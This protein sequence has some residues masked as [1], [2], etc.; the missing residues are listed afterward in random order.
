V[1]RDA[2]FRHINDTAVAFM[3]DDQPVISVDAKKKGLSASTP[4]PVRSTS[5]RRRRR[6]P[7]STTSLTPRW[8]RP[9]RTASMTSEPTRDGSRSATTLTP[10]ASPWPQ[11]AAGGPRWDGS[12]TPMPP[13]SSS[14]PMPA[15]RTAP[16]QGLEGRTRQARQRDR[17]RDHGLSL[18]PGLRSGTRSLSHG[19]PGVYEVTN[20]PAQTGRPRERTVISISSLTSC[21][22]RR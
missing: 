8:E 17:P 19:F 2:Q 3:A 20:E 10:P 14:V 1:D 18:P 5:R 15:G 4:T 16:D 6:E 9:S 22:S 7:T 11:S 12:A 21:M 13:V